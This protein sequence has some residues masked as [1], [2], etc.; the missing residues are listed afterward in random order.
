M[1]KT[2]Y[3]TLIDLVSEKLQEIHNFEDQ[4]DEDM[5]EYVQEL[6]GIIE[7]LQNEYEKCKAEAVTAAGG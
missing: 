2:D 7:G 6:E 5:V 1:T 4:D 3:A